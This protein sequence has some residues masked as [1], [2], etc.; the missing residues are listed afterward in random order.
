MECS[1][2]VAKEPGSCRGGKGVRGADDARRGLLPKYAHAAVEVGGSSCPVVDDAILLPEPQ[3]KGAAP[4]VRTQLPVEGPDVLPPGAKA[5]H[6]AMQIG[7]EELKGLIDWRWRRPLGVERAEHALVR[8][9]LE[10]DIVGQEGAQPAVCLLCLRLAERDECQTPL[11]NA[12]SLELE[13]GLARTR[14][15]FGDRRCGAV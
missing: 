2:E 11:L 5:G 15:A 4:V 8:A 3:G 12:C 7:S 9:H 6:F 1:L 14:M 10:F 13:G